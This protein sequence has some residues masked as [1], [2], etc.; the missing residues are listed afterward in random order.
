M[1]IIQIEKYG[2]ICITVKGRTK[3]SHTAEFE[4]MVKQIVEGEKR[5]LL[6]DF[7][8]LEYLRSSFLRVILNAVKQINQ[9][10]GKVVLCSLNGYVKE[11]FDV[12]TLNNN[13]SITESVESA[14]NMLLGSSKAA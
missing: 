3:E 11:I 2:I 1:E 13:I 7:S 4:K 12:N 5:R 9:K 8:A 10:H 14:L 6:F